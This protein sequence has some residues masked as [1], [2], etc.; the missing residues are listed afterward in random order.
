MPQLLHVVPVD[1]LAGLDRPRDLELASLGVGLPAHVDVVVVEADHNLRHLGPANS[2]GEDGTRGI[3]T[4]EASLALSGAIINDHN[5][6]FFF[7]DFL[8][9]LIKIYL[10]FIYFS[11]F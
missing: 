10:L 8:Y 3:I 4:G 11:Y 6:Y 5:R 7:H 2:R 1:D 9:F